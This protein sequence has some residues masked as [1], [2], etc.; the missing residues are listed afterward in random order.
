ME[1]ENTS[2]ESN[3]EPQVKGDIQRD[4]PE[5]PNPPEGGILADD[6]NGAPRLA[7][8]VDELLAHLNSFAKQHGFAIVRRQAGN[9]RKETG[10]YTRWSLCCD[11]DATRASQGLGL[12][13]TA[14]QKINCPWK[15]VATA[16]RGNDW[17]WSW[18]LRPGHERHNHGPSLHP[19]AHAT[20]RKLNDRQKDVLK[21]ISRHSSMRTR[22]ITAILNELSPGTVLTA[23]DIVNARQKLRLDDLDASSAQSTIGNQAPFISSTSG[24]ISTGA[25]QTPTRIPDAL[26]LRQD[27]LATKDEFVAGPSHDNTTFKRLFATIQGL[28]GGSSELGVMRGGHG[29]REQA[30]SGA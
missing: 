11:R 27:S 10:E 5:I 6:P 17:K 26:Q 7:A 12:R 22:E 4:Y 19:S 2:Q 20:H 23:K 13:K 21:A 14:T 24:E 18:Y 16:K 1:S 29:A 3:V 30:A 28:P 15:G 8:N 9:K 25:T